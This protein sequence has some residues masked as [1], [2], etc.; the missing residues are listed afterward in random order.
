[1]WIDY[2]VLEIATG[3]DDLIYVASAD[4]RPHVT[5]CDSARA[6]PPRLITGR[7]YYTPDRAL[8]LYAMVWVLILTAFIVF[9]LLSGSLQT[10]QVISDM[11]EVVVPAHF[12]KKVLAAE[13][14]PAPPRRRLFYDLTPFLDDIEDL[15]G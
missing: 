12:A 15:L 5:R 9:P 11:L 13:Y 2:F 6:G 8:A 4:P 1:M 10:L 3:A 14:T 7:S